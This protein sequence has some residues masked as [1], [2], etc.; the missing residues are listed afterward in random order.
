LVLDA[1]RLVV[2]DVDAV[3]R[4]VVLVARAPTTSPVGVTPGCRLSSSTTLR[5]MSGSC[6]TCCSPNALPTLA[7]VVFQHD[8]VGRHRHRFGQPRELH[9]HVQ[10]CRRVDL[11]RHPLLDLSKTLRAVPQFVGAGGHLR[12]LIRPGLVGDDV[13][14]ERGLRADQL[15]RHTGR[16]A[17]CASTILPRSEEVV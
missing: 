13:A 2:V 12:K 14:Q 9:L 10:R 17:P 5:V 1:G 7:S 3:E 6:R 11:Q 16:I 4:H 15:Q 8:R